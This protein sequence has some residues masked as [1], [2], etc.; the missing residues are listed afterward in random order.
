MA[1]K[2]SSTLAA[3]PVLDEEEITRLR[4]AVMRTARRLRHTAADEGLT[5]SQSG[6]LATLVREGPHG[7]G[8]LAAAEAL[9]PTML[10]RILAHLAERGLVERAPHSDDARRAVVR[11]TPAGRRLVNRLR[12][13]RIAVLEAGIAELRPDHAAALRA[14][15]PALEALAQIDEAAR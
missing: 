7:A 4:N 11:A 1:S 13:R 6:V 10:S 15:L 3:P 2:R 5:P 14:A 8:E 9:H 12:S